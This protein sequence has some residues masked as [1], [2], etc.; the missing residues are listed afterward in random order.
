VLVVGGTTGNDTIVF[1]PVGKTGIKVLIGGKLQG[2]FTEVGRIAAYGQAGND[3]IQV[4]GSIQV[5]A[6]LYGGDGN[7]RLK[8]GA[9]ANVLLGGNGNDLLL[10]GRRNDVIVG[11]AGADQLIGGPGSDLLI[12]GTTS[13]DAN[14][15]ALFAISKV[16]A[17]SDSFATRV[18]NLRAGSTPLVF[19]GGGATVFADTSR[20]H[21]VGASGDN[22][23]F[24]DPLDKTTGKKKGSVV[25]DV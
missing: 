8:G 7:D 1:V 25:N 3:N 16:W 6:W 24:A 22:W 14:D 4:A 13:Y 2:S 9:G 19:T 11:G 21:L 5:P 20:D 12:G 15:A 17:S 10:G 23:F 18:A